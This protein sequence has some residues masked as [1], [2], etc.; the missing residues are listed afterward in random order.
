VLGPAPE[1]ALVPDPGRSGESTGPHTTES[2]PPSPTA[3]PAQQQQTLWPAASTGFVES[4]AHLVSVL[5][6]SLRSAGL[7]GGG[8]RLLE[9]EG[10]RVELTLPSNVAQLTLGRCLATALG[11]R[12]DYLCGPP[13]PYGTED[14]GTPTVWYGIPHQHNNCPMNGTGGSRRSAVPYGIPYGTDH[15]VFA[16]RRRYVGGGLH[17]FGPMFRRNEPVFIEFDVCASSFFNN[18]YRSHLFT[19]FP[20][21]A[22]G[23]SHHHF[24]LNKDLSQSPVSEI[25]VSFF[26]CRGEPVYFSSSLLKLDHLFAIDLEFRRR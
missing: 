19:V 24:S 1:P 22:A 7:P 11:L 26:D 6:R 13:D 23:G 3:P 8:F 16:E 25:V 18:S 12:G 15:Q 17:M 4:P 9:E 14:G 2:G 20:G 21:A 10:G 5:N